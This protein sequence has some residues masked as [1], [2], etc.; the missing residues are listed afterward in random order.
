MGE[1]RLN[2]FR[3]HIIT[4]P[5][6]RH[7][8][9]VS[10][11]VSLEIT[12]LAVKLSS[13][14][15]SDD[16]FVAGVEAHAASFIV[17]GHVNYLQV[18]SSAPVTEETQVQVSSGTWLCEMAL[19]LAWTHVGTAS[20]LT[21]AEL[22][23]VDSKGLMQALSRHRYISGVAVEYCVIY[24]EKVRKAVP[25]L[26][27]PT[28]ISVP[29]ASYIDIVDDMMPSMRSAIGMLA[30]RNQ[31][32]KT[33]WTSGRIAKLKDEVMQ[34]AS[35]VIL[36]SSGELERSVRVIAV[37]VACHEDD[38]LW[39]AHIG[40]K[41]QDRKPLGFCQLPGSK[42]APHETD[43]AA[44]IRVLQNEL[45]LPLVCHV[46]VDQF[47]AEHTETRKMSRELGVHTRYAKTT[48]SL[49]ISD[50]NLKRGDFGVGIADSDTLSARTSFHT[51]D[52]IDVV[53]GGVGLTPPMPVPLAPRDIVF[54]RDKEK[55]RFYTWLSPEQ[56]AK[57]SDERFEKV[58]SRFLSHLQCGTS[59]EKLALGSATEDFS[60][61]SPC[62]QRALSV[63]SRQSGPVWLGRF[64]SS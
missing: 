9:G 60:C 25:P 29:H 49:K 40:T 57:L 52:E 36:N 59:Q 62:E 27:Y 28:D 26:A 44:V 6:F 14:H 33:M 37:Q 47:P 56:F 38:V 55:T 13:W 50:M 64:A 7:C 51:N 31:D 5:L 34:G 43:A 46:D 2:V 15:A 3:H 63:N 42:R 32:S 21:G 16:I 22:I 61:Y 48:F 35:T 23:R 58:I 17:Q 8:M 30:V 39:L 24:A 18:P 54:V 41:V 45:M 20:A 53:H 1:L 19:W 12:A 11:T 10:I 4:H